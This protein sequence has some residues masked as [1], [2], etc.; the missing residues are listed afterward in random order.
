MQETM[1]KMLLLGI[2]VAALTQEKIEEM[3]NEW[4]SKGDLSREEGKSLVK[5]FV[6]KSQ[7]QA[8]KLRESVQTEVG[9][10]VPKPL[11][12]ATAEDLAELDKRLQKLERQ[13]A[14]LTATLRQATAE[15]PAQEEGEDT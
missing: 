12:P 11:P 1:R 14:T 7:E 4:V 5:E 8:G 13:V 9:K 15:T 6:A 3:V 2:G 10:R